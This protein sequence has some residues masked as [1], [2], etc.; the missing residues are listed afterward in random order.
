MSEV[1][2]STIH[3]VVGCVKLHWYL[4]IFNFIPRLR[5][6]IEYVVIVVSGKK[7]TQTRGRERK[8]IGGRTFLFAP[9]CASISSS[10]FPFD[11]FIS[12]RRKRLF[13][14]LAW[15]RKHECSNLLKFLCKFWVF[16]TIT[17]FYV[18]L[19][20]FR[21]NIDILKDNFGEASCYPS[22][23]VATRASKLL[24]SFP[25]VL[26]NLD[27]EMWRKSNKIHNLGLFYTRQPQDNFI[28]TL[29]SS[30]VVRLR[31]M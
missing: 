26:R 12:R 13:F 24:S 17:V 3:T 23:Q 28:R 10:Q 5:L 20:N 29:F 9:V 14:S 27:H 1:T 4:G 30:E 18:N 19:A 6:Q 11:F 16:E 31:F 7:R 25:T 8:G 15:E 21:C 22:K 2:P